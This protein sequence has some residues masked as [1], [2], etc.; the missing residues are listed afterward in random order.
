MLNNVYF[1]FYSHLFST[2]VCNEK[3]ENFKKI[4]MDWNLLKLIVLML[5]IY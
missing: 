5:L 4:N 2:S 3:L 1:Y